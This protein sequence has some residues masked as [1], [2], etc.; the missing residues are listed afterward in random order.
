MRLGRAN[1]VHAG[2]DFQ[3]PPLLPASRQARERV[4][5]A[6]ALKPGWY[7]VS[8]TLLQG[9]GYMIHAPDGEWVVVNENALSYFQELVP[10]DRSGYSI[11][12]YKVESQ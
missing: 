9:R 3:L 11:Y 8:V 10:T 4:K 7:A 1:P 6:R 2:I 5:V 12:L